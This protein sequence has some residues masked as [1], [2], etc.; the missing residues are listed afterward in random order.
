M[1]QSFIKRAQKNKESLAW[2]IIP[3]AVI[4]GTRIR[5]S[6]SP[7]NLV[8]IIEIKNVTVHF[9]SGEYQLDNLVIPVSQIYAWG[10][11]DETFDHLSPHTTD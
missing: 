8:Q 1:F 2:F 6:S 11:D 3:G 7:D 5:T 9:G 10:A 4:M